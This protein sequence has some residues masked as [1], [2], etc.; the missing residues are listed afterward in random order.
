[1]KRKCFF[2]LFLA[3]AIGLPALAADAPTIIKGNIWF[4]LIPASWSKEG[5]NYLYFPESYDSYREEVSKFVIYD[6]DFNVVN[7]I[8]PIKGTSYE[9]TTY[10]QQRKYCPEFATPD[11]MDVEVNNV[12]T[13]NGTTT[14]LTID[15]VL[16]EISNG[17]LAKLEDGTQVVAYEFFEPSWYGKKYPNYFFIEQDGEWHHARIYYNTS[18]NWGPYGEWEDTQ[19]STNTYVACPIDIS[20]R[21]ADGG[22][23]NYYYLTK[24]LFSEDFNYILPEYKVVSINNEYADS[25]KPDWITQ[26]TW[27]EV[28]I[29]TAYVVYD[30]TGKEVMRFD[31]PSG[32]ESHRDEVSY[33]RVGENRYVVMDMDNSSTGES[34]VAVY[35]I[36]ESNKVSQVALAP[37]S[38]V[39]PRAPKKGEVVTVTVDSPV[40]GDGAIVQVVSAS[41]QSMLN[42]KIPAG[43]NKLD[44]NTS[45]FSQGMYVVTVSGNGVSKEAAKIIVR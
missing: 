16:S 25:E 33:I 14:G 22:Q 15:Q 6:E 20:V 23:S 9:T 29:I 45:G 12:L 7:N 5:K 10:S 43:Q 17:E 40:G 38:K 28:C 21:T 18:G 30:S 35:K 4:E 34:Y 41:G 36:S 27:G 42:T 2:S 11:F 19:E 8:V 32:Y 26:K 37:C 31:I 39:S 44:I 13:I 1:M 3:V 24:G